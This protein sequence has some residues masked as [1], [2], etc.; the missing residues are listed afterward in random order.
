[1]A[2]AGNGIVV[3]VEGHISQHS[4]SRE[5]AVEQTGVDFRDVVVAQIH[6]DFGSGVEIETFFGQFGYFVVAEIQC[7]KAR[8][9]LPR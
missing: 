8:Q 2:V 9:M 3:D 6:L 4:I 1:M 5:S 7:L